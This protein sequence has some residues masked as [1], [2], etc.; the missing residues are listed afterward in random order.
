M[1]IYPALPIVLLGLS[2]FLFIDTYARGG[3]MGGGMAGV[4]S[5]AAGGA[6]MRSA[7]VNY[8]SLRPVTSMSASPGVR[9]V[10][11]NYQNVGS[12]DL[13]DYR[14]ESQS[15]ETRRGGD[16]TVGVSPS[17]DVGVRG[18]TAGGRQYAGVQSYGGDRVVAG[19]TASGDI[20]VRARGDGDGVIDVL[21]SGYKTIHHDHHDYYYSNYRYYWPYYY[22]GTVYYQ[23]I[24][25][26]YGTTLDELPADA[27]Q[28]NT[29]GTSYY[30]YDDVYYAAEGDGQ[31]YEVV[32]PPA[33]SAE[34]VVDSENDPDKL[35]KAMCEYVGSFSNFVV[36]SLEQ[37]ERPGKDSATVKRRILVSR[38]DR[39]TA[40]GRDGSAVTRFWYD[41]KTVAL[42]DA[43]KNV[44]SKAV[45]PPTIRETVEMLQDEYGLALPLADLLLPELYQMLKT[46]IDNLGYAG[47]DVVDGQ[48]CHKI[49]FS[50]ENYEA[51]IWITADAMHPLP[52]KI[53]V[54][55]QTADKKLQYVGVINGWKAADDINP[56]LFAFTPPEGSREIEMLKR[57]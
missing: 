3:R 2:A 19:E 25:P 4:R 36:D 31:G 22:G 26:P 38:P 43:E 30:M 44:Y 34:P 5:S 14:G 33:G 39:I 37:V 40:A 53:D 57:P 17:G 55:Y 27:V 45:A 47:K 10:S 23:E 8:G 11:P 56:E 50:T 9:T 13:N 32:A 46:E 24:Y 7:P 15:F 29:N 16:V 12:R 20:A 35:L 6:A 52:R 1:R 41:G 54:M 21:P 18:E 28:V 48:D 42:L 49:T 51:A